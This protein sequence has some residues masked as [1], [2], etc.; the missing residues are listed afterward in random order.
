MPFRFEAFDTAVS[1]HVFHHLVGDSQRGSRRRLEAALKGVARV[2][3]PGGVLTVVDG[4]IAGW[5]YPVERA[6]FPFVM[7]VAGL[8][9]A[10]PVMFRSLDLL[11]SAMA[12]AGFTVHEA[13][14]LSPSGKALTPW[15]TSWSWPM[16]LSPLRDAIVVAQKVA[17]QGQGTAGAE[18]TMS[19]KGH[20]GKG[21]P[22]V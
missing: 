1:V 2:L 19:A 4:V 6:L 21:G 11:V 15:G 22:I 5:L 3:R 10:P 17:S 9:H 7:F 8:F 13:K 14:A 16:R 20:T 18:A 12:E